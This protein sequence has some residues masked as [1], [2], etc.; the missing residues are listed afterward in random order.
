MKNTDLT[1]STEQFKPEI[2]SLQDQI[3]ELVIT[4]DTDI[5]IASNTVVKINNLKKKIENQRLAFTKPLNESLRNINAFFKQFS[6][7][8]DEA[9]GEIRNK[10]LKYRQEQEKIRLEKEKEAQRKWKE[11]QARLA[12][13]AKERGVEAPELEKPVVQKQDSAIGAMKFKKYWVFEVQDLSK[14]PVEYLQVN[15]KAVNE[16]IRAGR[17]RITGIKIYQE[18]RSSL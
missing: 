12:E 16:A 17:R 18:E 8:L 9:N 13:K 6:V 14:V 1:Q 2:K 15:E 11:E 4:S 5:E 3:N 7:P 10:M